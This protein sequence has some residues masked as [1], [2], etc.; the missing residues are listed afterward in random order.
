[1]K[2]APIAL[3]VYRRPGH[4]REVVQ[5]LTK[6]PMASSSHLH[7][8]SDAASDRSYENDVAEVRSYIRNIR[9]FKSVSI[10]ERKKNLGLAGSIIDG[11]SRLCRDHGRVIVLED[12]IIVSPYFLDYMNAALEHYASE[13]KVMHISGYMFPVREPDR[14]PQT[15]FYRGASC[16]GWATWARA[17]ELFEPD[18]A[19]LLKRILESRRERDFDILDTM[20]YTRMLHEQMKGEVDSWAIRWYASI[21]LRDGLCLHPARSLTRNIGH[22]GSGTH[23]D[24]SHIYDT[25]VAQGSVRI[26]PDVIVEC[27]TALEAMSEFYRSAKNPPYTR[28]L[29]RFA[30]MLRRRQNAR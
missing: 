16:W 8:F 1:M 12:D 29:R 7:V 9:G 25:P 2:P 20:H 6:N 15:F 22:D 10:V 17:W 5:N 3:F 18:A 11:V 14:L 30:D 24:L 28:L 19:N 26:F 13:E 23:C 21:F 4:T 27:R